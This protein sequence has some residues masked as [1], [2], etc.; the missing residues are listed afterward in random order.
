MIFH[1]ENRMKDRAQNPVGDPLKGGI[2][3][4]YPPG[5][6]A[7]TSQGPRRMTWNFRKN[8]RFFTLPAL[9]VILFATSNGFPAE[10]SR[11]PRVLI[12]KDGI[13]LL[14]ISAG[15]FR[16][17]S[18]RSEIQAAVKMAR[19]HHPV[20]R[21]EWFE[22]EL[23]ARKVFV[24]SFYIDEI[25]ITI[26]KY[27]KITN[28]PRWKN[29]KLRHFFRAKS[30]LLPGWSIGNRE[31]LWDAPVANIQW[32]EAEAYCRRVGRRLPSSD[33]W[34][35]AAR[36]IHGR[37][38]PWGNR[39]DPARLNSYEAGVRSAVAAGRYSSGASPY[40]VLDMAGNVWEWTT[41]WYDP[42]L[43]KVGRRR[44]IRG[45]GWGY[46]GAFA[47]TANLGAVWPGERHPAL[48][49]RCAMSP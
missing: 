26:S 1:P 3:H 16:K 45:G 32:K 4:N 10:S 24:P 19:R 47:R 36:G 9:L 25:E 48:G 14:L 20:V 31:S 17:G 35:K 39:F 42:A 34:E 37:I 40:G 28:S 5:W 33:E 7:W 12:G 2:N 13:R 49:F 44:I 15:E 18:T 41:D 29:R 43:R 23:P 30:S 11:L 38:F 27:Y 21:P 46:G 6:A 22:D 8:A